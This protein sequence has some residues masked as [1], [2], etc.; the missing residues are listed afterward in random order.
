[1]LKKTDRSHG[2]SNSRKPVSLQDELSDLLQCQ[3]QPND[4]DESVSKE[5]GRLI[6]SSHPQSDSRLLEGMKVQSSIQSDGGQDQL[7]E[8]SIFILSNPPPTTDSYW[9]TTTS[10]T[11]LN[12]RQHNVTW[13][14]QSMKSRPLLLQQLDSHIG[15]NSGQWTHHVNLAKRYIHCIRLH[16]INSDKMTSYIWS[17]DRQPVTPSSVFKVIIL[18]DSGVGKT[19]FIRR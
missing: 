7:S 8:K 6:S 10:V 9:S 13:T 2:E 3:Q 16:K 17:T 1:L 19:S 12:Q 15:Y 14:F 18:G 4:A 11:N 5:G